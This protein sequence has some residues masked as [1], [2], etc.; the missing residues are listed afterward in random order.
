[1]SFRPLR[2]KRDR[3]LQVN[4]CGSHVSLLTHHVTEQV[5]CLGVV[6]IEGKGLAELFRSSLQIPARD[7]F[8]PAL[9]QIVPR[10]PCGLRRL[11]FCRALLLQGQAEPV[12]TFPQFRIDTQCFL[13][14]SNRPSQ[15]SALAP[16]LSQLV[17]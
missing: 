15:L 10:T 4:Q 11:S 9:V 3:A 17:P 5:V 12:V 8:P 13:E 16:R 2:P 14:G 6:R 1:M 7:C